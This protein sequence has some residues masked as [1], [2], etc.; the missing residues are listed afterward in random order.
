MIAFEALAA[1]LPVPPDYSWNW[2]GLC[3]IAPVKRLI[4]AMARTPQHPAW[5]GEGDVWTH[6]RMV[7]EALSGL[8]DFRAMDA[9]G[10]NALALAALLHDIGKPRCTRLEDGIL[11]TPRHGPVGARLAR[12][13]L[14][15]DLGL[16]STPGAQALREAVCL[17]VRYH[18]KPLHFIDD[19]FPEAEMLRLA[20]DGELA[21]LFTLK[22]LCL[23]AEAD[24]LGSLAADNP[25]MLERIE[26]GREL[27]REAGCLEG[28]YPFPSAHT[29]RRMFS[30]GQVWKDAALYDDTWGEVTL[31]CGL[32][33]T[34]KDTWIRDHCPDLPVVSLDDLRREM[35]VAPTEDQG[36]VIQ[37]ARERAKAYLRSRQPFVWNATSLTAR[38]AQQIELFEQYHAR[39]RVVFL[40]TA[41]AEN[42]RRNAD[43]AEAV[44][45]AVV[46]RMLDA[47]EPPERS[48]AQAVAWV[49][50]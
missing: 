27:A 12:A 2:A 20:A 14:W 23:L 29:G 36:R 31:M 24:R 10:R 15:R 6:T 39:T 48:E 47:L 9:C 26:L 13:L 18:T 33:G 21:P 17:L 45:E 38:R 42:L 30:G 19:G 46:S 28:P 44:P 43:R 34:G 8:P 11:V 40:E 49:C 32:P 16:C 4:D 37:A 50:V 25:Q 22:R 41:W 5:H 3:N 7:C 1:C 35:G